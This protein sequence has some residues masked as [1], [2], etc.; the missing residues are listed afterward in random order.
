M[1]FGGM[2][3]PRSRGDNGGAV[4]F[5]LENREKRSG[6]RRMFRK[7]S[8]RPTI[9]E[10]GTSRRL[11]AGVIA[12]V[13]HCDAPHTR[14]LAE[15]RRF[16]IPGLV[17]S[18]GYSSLR[19]RHTECRRVN[20]LTLITRSVMIP[21]N[22]SELSGVRN[23]TGVPEEGITTLAATRSSD[24]PSQAPGPGRCR[25]TSRS[26]ASAWKSPREAHR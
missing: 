26:A 11:A 9:S 3:R 17:R 23:G 4:R 7:P 5:S 18:T 19:S 13:A 21:P 14:R 6:W 15:C 1:T 24:R 20:T 10:C 12:P 22:D 2:V 16:E 8:C 25:I